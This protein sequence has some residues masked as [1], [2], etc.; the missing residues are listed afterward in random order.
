MAGYH[1]EKKSEKDCCEE[2]ALHMLE[3]IRVAVAFM[4]HD[5]EVPVVSLTP[6]NDL[7]LSWK[8]IS[9]RIDQKEAKMIVRPTVGAEIER[10]K[11]GHE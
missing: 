6:G 2:T 8:N 3:C 4:C 1:V 5:R 10:R 9:V 11:G 7:Y